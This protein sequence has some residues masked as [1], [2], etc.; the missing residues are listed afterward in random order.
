MCCIAVKPGG[1]HFATVEAL[2]ARRNEQTK[3]LGADR[4]GI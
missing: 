4:N 3:A 1:A 2:D